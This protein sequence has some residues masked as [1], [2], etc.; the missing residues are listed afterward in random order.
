MPLGIFFA[1]SWWLDTIRIPWALAIGKSSQMG[2]QA[3]DVS[4]TLGQTAILKGV[5]LD[6]APGKFIALLGPSGCGKTTLLRVLAGLQEVS[7]GAVFFEGKNITIA[8]PAE[9]NCG[10]V[11]QSLA[12]FPHLNVLENIMFPL[13]KLDLT[14][15]ERIE[16][17]SNLLEMVRMTQ[18]RERPM[19]M[20]SG[21][22]AQRVAIARALAQEPSLLLLDEPFSALDAEL[23]EE[24]RT[25]IRVIQRKLGISV[26]MVT[27]D[28]HEAFTVSDLVGVMN[29]G[30]MEQV[31]TPDDL[32]REPATSFVAKFVGQRN[33]I[34]C[35]YREG[36]L[37]EAGTN[38]LISHSCSSLKLSPYTK[39]DLYYSSE[40]ITTKGQIEVEALYHRNL[41]GRNEICARYKEQTIWIHNLWSGQPDRVSFGVDLSE[42]F[43]F[44]ANDD[45]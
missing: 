39:Y 7:A 43:I 40:A 41:G 11:F 22:Q 34:S 18:F 30:K 45:D 1:L 13:K 12:L 5:D 19:S 15:S 9:R 17:A 42:S 23:R 27:H 16:R 10:M 28:Q 33:H 2:L 35:F 37:Y 44:E 21:G 4:V 36:G 29:E 32:I 3:Q 38:N 6:I 25:E 26:V 20:I 24:L 31:G 8:K 14:K